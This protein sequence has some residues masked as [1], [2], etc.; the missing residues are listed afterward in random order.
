VLAR[1]ENDRES[2][3]ER[4]AICVCVDSTIVLRFI[5][6]YDPI[7]TTRTVVHSVVFLST[8]THNIVEFCVRLEFE[9]AP[10]FTTGRDVPS[11]E[12][13]GVSL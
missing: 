10:I 13:R 11:V 8:D 9:S 5:C 12:R 4:E 1:W 2:E 3:G 6:E 7:F